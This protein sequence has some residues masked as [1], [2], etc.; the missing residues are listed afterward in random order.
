MLVLAFLAGFIEL[1]E[2]H[3]ADGQRVF[4][5]PT[6]I[7]S[8]REPIKGDLQRHFTAGSHCVVVMT[9]G[10]F[11]ATREDCDT[12]RDKVGLKPPM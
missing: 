5:N 2:L 3:G 6:E 7:T 10:K 11:I 1:V 8:I 4:I 9:D 12:V